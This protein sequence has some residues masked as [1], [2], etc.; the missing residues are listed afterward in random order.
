LII[1]RIRCA[2]KIIFFNSSQ[3]KANQKQKMSGKGGRREKKSTSASSKAGLQFPFGRIGHYLCQGK[4]AIRMG[5]GAPVVYL[6]AVLEYLCAEI[7]ELA[8]NEV[9]D[10]KKIRIVPCHLTLAIKNDKELNKLLGGV[11]IAS[12]GVLP[13]IHA[14]LLPK[15]STTK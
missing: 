3:A 12:G 15:K 11:M 2:H 14:I 8:S 10:S 13:N 4:Y 1:S 7:L 6:A 5:A 9:H